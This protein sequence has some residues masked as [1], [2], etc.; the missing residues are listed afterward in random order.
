MMTVELDGWPIAELGSGEH[1]IVYTGKGKTWVGAWWGY[2]KFLIGSVGFDAEGGKEY[3]F[4]IAIKE[5]RI[6]AVSV[7][8]AMAGAGPGFDQ[9]FNIEM[10]EADLGRKLL[11]DS[12]DI[13]PKKPQE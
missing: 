12:T 1:I 4:H 11:E 9:V 13:T 5:M 7:L 6:S 3:Y 10:I 8:F 2:K